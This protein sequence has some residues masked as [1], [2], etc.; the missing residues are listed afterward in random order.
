MPRRRELLA[1]MLAAPVV[2]AATG[3]FELDVDSPVLRLGFGSCVSQ[4]KPQ[5]IW[6]HVAQHDPHAFV[7]MGDGI[8]PEH[9]GMDMPVADAIDAAYRVAAGRTE[10]AEF[11]DRV[12]VIA[13]WDDNDYGG[14][15]IGR[16][17]A[18]KERSKQRFLEFWAN[19]KE[20][21]LRDRDDGIYAAW[22]FGAA[23]RRTQIIVPDLRF[24]RSEWA[25]VEDDFRA[26]LAGSGF[27]PY[28]A[29]TAPDA[30]MLGE[31]QW[32]WLADCLRRPARLRIIVSSIQCVPTGRGW[33]SWSN[34]PGER[35]RLFALLRD[36]R[37][38]GVV[39][40]S[41]DTHY[42]E[43]SRSDEA[44]LGYPLWEFTS[45]GLTEF[46][47]TPGPNPQRVGDAFPVCNFGI[48]RVSWQT[49]DPLLVVEFYDDNGH[50]LRQ[51]SLR[52]S[53]LDA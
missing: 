22:E 15:D 50:R 48:L 46:W 6:S 49:G 44:R 30:R 17:F 42:A 25:Q 52:L 10:L 34:F 24:C 43:V 8:Y 18:H 32:T 21:R 7:L 27:G 3:P 16:T 31:R 29:T 14:S 39:I 9:E 26:E 23:G 20:A 11:R 19:S 47:P 40:L 1:A 51:Q 45:S 4:R 38:S 53:E 28:R 36:T 5:T 33:E 12:P 35:A 41:G 2:G 37:A 13:T